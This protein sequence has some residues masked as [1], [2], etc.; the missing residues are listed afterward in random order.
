MLARNS[1]ET[2]MS[3][4]GVPPPMSTSGFTSLH[5]ASSH[6]GS[7]FSL[8]NIISE[9]PEHCQLAQWPLV[10]NN[11]RRS[12]ESWLD[13]VYRPQINFN[14]YKNKL[15]QLLNTPFVISPEEKELHA[16]ASVLWDQFRITDPCQAG[17]CQ[18][19]LTNL[20]NRGGLPYMTSNEADR[21]YSWSW[22]RKLL[23]ILVCMFS[24][25][26]F[27]DQ[28][29]SNFTNIETMQ[30]RLS[31]YLYSVLN[32]VRVNTLRFLHFFP[33]VSEDNQFS[34]RIFG[35]IVNWYDYQ[36]RRHCGMIRRA[37][38]FNPEEYMKVEKLAF[39]LLVNA[40]L[41]QHKFNHPIISPTTPTIGILRMAMTMRWMPRYDTSS[42]T[43][44]GT[45][46]NRLADF[47]SSYSNNRLVVAA[48]NRVGGLDSDLMGIRNIAY[49]AHM[50]LNSKEMNCIWEADTK[51]QAT[52]RNL[53]YTILPQLHTSQAP[54]FSALMNPVPYIPHKTH[55]LQLVELY[56]LI[57]NTWDFQLFNE[58]DTSMKA[59]PQQWRFC[60]VDNQ[61]SSVCNDYF[62]LIQTFYITSTRV[63][64]PPRYLCADVYCPSLHDYRT[65]IAAP[66]SLLYVNQILGMA[67]EIRI[68]E[69]LEDGQIAG[70][71]YALM[72]LNRVWSD[73]EPK[74]FILVLVL[75]ILFFTDGMIG[76]FPHAVSIRNSI[77]ESLAV[78]DRVLLT[79]PEKETQRPLYT[80]WTTRPPNTTVLEYLYRHDKSTTIKL[81]INI[82][83]LPVSKS[84]AKITRPMAEYMENLEISSRPIRNEAD[85]DQVE[86]AHESIE[87]FLQDFEFLRSELCFSDSNEDDYVDIG[88]PRSKILADTRAKMTTPEGY[89][90][91]AT[92]IASLSCAS[93]ELG[94]TKER[95]NQLIG[96]IPKPQHKEVAPHYLCTPTY[97]SERTITTFMRIVGFIFGINPFNFTVPHN[98]SIPQFHGVDGSFTD[99]VLPRYEHPGT[100]INPLYSALIHSFGKYKVPSDG[101]VTTDG[102]LRFLLATKPQTESNK[103]KLVAASS[104]TSTNS[105]SSGGEEEKEM[106][107]EKKQRDEQYKTSQTVTKHT[108]STLGDFEMDP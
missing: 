100:V 56:D 96:P 61:I 78:I 50:M 14:C 87:A 98:Q 12:F 70:L 23:F 73:E 58:I 33:P 65:L 38:G 21:V 104:P 92:K 51:K 18:V 28:I 27:T 81:M 53:I 4:I 99:L 15:K 101:A 16:I 74:L 1:S 83:L 31:G 62:K 91:T 30:P 7:K 71:G 6:L 95:F 105:N 85:S 32:L 97:S 86:E 108:N 93:V 10:T 90:G 35:E 60:L 63:N 36:Y 29:G 39:L 80:D 13:I 57:T 40:G 103:R 52:L 17:K 11:P 19:V 8:L 59:Y 24:T 41:Q 44:E 77:K 79:Q 5:H 49:C 72:T 26:E 43:V 94:I 42:F 48:S 25:T 89:A 3:S 34:A 46:T 54:S 64:Q 37:P 106:E 107:K 47:T 82:L 69:N 55:Y 67:E 22:Q 88:S 102:S 84:T 20:T 2:P 66:N 9:Y 76:V 75:K 45:T 68:T